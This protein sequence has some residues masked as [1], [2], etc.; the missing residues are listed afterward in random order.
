MAKE[1]NAVTME[2]GQIP[3]QPLTFNKDG[4]PRKEDDLIAYCWSKYLDTGE[5]TWLPRLPMVKSVV[6][7]M[8]AATEFL[9]S[10]EGGGVKLK[11]FV[12]AGGSKRGWT[13]WLTGVVDPRVVAIVPIVIDIVNV[14]ATMGNHYSAYGFWAPAVGDYLEHK[15]MQRSETPA[16]AEM[17]KIIDPYSYR[18][19]LTMPKL[20]LNAAGDQFFTPDS[21]RFYSR[22]E[23]PKFL[24]YV[25]MAI[26]A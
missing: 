20:I 3:N 19:R 2:L 1:S 9:A 12:V 22:P 6:R 10:E 5:A 11:H 18:H 16:Y 15:V 23:G 26:T 24:R 25:L 13:T 7:A 4:T 17:L 14:R 8:D 21:S